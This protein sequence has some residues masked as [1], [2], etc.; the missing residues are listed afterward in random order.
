MSTTVPDNVSLK[1]AV[2]LNVNEVVRNT[3]IQLIAQQMA[4]GSPRPINFRGDIAERF[5]YDKIQPLTDGRVFG[6]VVVIRGKSQKTGTENYYQILSN[7]WK[8]LEIVAV[9]DE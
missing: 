8:L 3:T 2:T 5:N 7:Q 6:N 1:N 4:S 9:L